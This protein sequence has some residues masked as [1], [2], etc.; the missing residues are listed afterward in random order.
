MALPEQVVVY[1]TAVQT[2]MTSQTTQEIGTM[3][4][5]ATGTSLQTHNVARHP[6]AVK[7]YEK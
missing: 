7:C 6:N 5:G 3:V 1:D 4:A 2:A